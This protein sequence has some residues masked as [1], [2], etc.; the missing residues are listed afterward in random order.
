MVVDGCESHPCRARCPAC[1]ERCMDCVGHTECKTASQGFARLHSCRAHV[2]GTIGDFN[3][4]CRSQRALNR[5]EYRDEL[6]RAYD[7]A[8]RRMR[9]GIALVQA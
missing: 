8:S 2:W 7:Q 3:E 4:V 6:E 9:K 1:S 5:K